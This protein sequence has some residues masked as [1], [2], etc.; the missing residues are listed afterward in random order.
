MRLHILA[1]CCAA[2]KYC[3]IPAFYSRYQTKERFL[4]VNKSK[5]AAEKAFNEDY[6]DIEG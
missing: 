6:F 5:I 4:R 3:D 2:K 1:C